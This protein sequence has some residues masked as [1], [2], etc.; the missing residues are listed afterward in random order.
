MFGESVH[1]RMQRD[2]AVLSDR[3]KYNLDDRM[4]ALD[5]FEMLIEDIDNANLI[6]SSG[7]WPLLVKNMFDE[8]S[9][10]QVRKELIG[11]ARTA[12][13]NN[14]KGQVALTKQNVIPRF[15]ELLKTPSSGDRT[16]DA[17][18]TKAIGCLSSLLNHNGPAIDSFASFDGF[19]LMSKLL[20]DAQ[21]DVSWRAAH[22]AMKLVADES[23]EQA[24]R[25]QFENHLAPV[26]ENAQG[27]IT[28]RALSTSSIAPGAPLESV[29]NPQVP[30]P[31]K[32]VWTHLVEA[33]IASTLVDIVTGGP[34]AVISD[35]T[36]RPDYYESIAETLWSFLARENTKRPGEISLFGAE[37]LSRLCGWYE[38]GGASTSRLDSEAFSAQDLWARLEK[39]I[40]QLRAG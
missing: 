2:L 4:T 17:L 38:A 39:E 19:D 20:T 28:T 31:R 24:P 1:A 3:E 37:A 8:E 32:T 40:K 34:N 30:P 11:I 12:V 23:K 7:W 36:L 5:E 29:A 35:F 15:I 13:Q 26:E 10:L 16:K 14:P 6:Q 18:R 9:E 25:E 27:A 22:L 33:R 21:D